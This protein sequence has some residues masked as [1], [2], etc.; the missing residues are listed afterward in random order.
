MFVNDQ[1]PTSREKMGWHEVNG[2]R[3]LNKYH[4]LENCPADHWPRWNFNNDV[5]R[6]I[7][8]GKEPEEDLYDIYKQRALQL[9][10]NYDYLLLL[11][12]RN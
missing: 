10:K 4:A 8:W 9:R 11:Q 12:R 1:M 2:I 7:D 6:L 5:Y 3:Y